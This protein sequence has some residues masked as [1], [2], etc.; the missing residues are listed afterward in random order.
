[1]P[2]RPVMA[3]DHFGDRFMVLHLKTLAGFDRQHTG[4]GKKG[5][6]IDRIVPVGKALACDGWWDGY[7]RLQKWSRCVVLRGPEGS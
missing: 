3:L 1:M 6:G 7:D 4:G 5:R 2:D